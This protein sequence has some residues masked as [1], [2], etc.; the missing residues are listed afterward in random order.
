[1]SAQEDSPPR[2][3]RMPAV[4]YGVFIGAAVFAIAVVIVMNQFHSRLEQAL[5][6][7]ERQYDEALQYATL[8]RHV[9]GYAQESAEVLSRGGEV[10]E[11]ETHKRAARRI[12]TE[13]GVKHELELMTEGEDEVSA[14]TR[15]AAAVAELFETFVQRIDELARL[16]RAAPEYK[17]QVHVVFDQILRQKLLPA[18]D[19]A[20]DGERVDADRN[21]TEYRG[22]V[23]TWTW[24]VAV[25]LILIGALSVPLYVRMDRGVRRLAEG[26]RRIAAGD[27]TARVA[28]RGMFRP[29]ADAF[30]GMAQRVHE[31]QQ[32]QLKMAKELQA[33]SAELLAVAKQ[34]ETNAADESSAVEET[35]RT[36][37]ALLAS[38]TDIAESAD[39][40]AASAEQSTRA[41]EGIGEQIL[42]LAAQ[43]QKIRKITALIQG[44]ADKSD[45]L[46]L[47]ASLE[48]VKAGEA[49]RGFVLLGSEMRRLAESVSS[50]ANEAG[51]LAF[52]I[53]ELSKRAVIST[54][55][56]QKLAQATLESSKRINLITSQQRGATEQVTRSMDDVHQYTQHSLAAA[57]QTRATASDLVRTS[58]ELETLVAASPGALEAGA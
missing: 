21:V 46:A 31:H 25:I 13:L 24:G 8:V 39:Q 55:V 51:D 45:V 12:L 58:D 50:A 34:T 14:D 23:T 11:R 38:A 4:S 33:S 29:I 30:N 28:E 2:W 52:E 44:I 22:D 57:K 47:N 1:M 19:R 7:V 48:G 27:Y 42:K 43:S 36:M 40:V 18:I 35:R 37:A 15:E 17:E 10:S 9:Q 32:A 20:Q 16:D 53:E 54:E 5:D 3:P 49:G 26:A 41:S 6:L 56:G